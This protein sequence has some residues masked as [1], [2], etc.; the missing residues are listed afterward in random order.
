M[1]VLTGGETSGASRRA[2]ETVTTETPVFAAMSFR[3]VMGFGG[4]TLPP[5]QCSFL[6]KV[7]QKELPAKCIRRT[8]WRLRRTVTRSPAS[9]SLTSW[10]SALRMVEGLG[11]MM[12][13]SIFVVRGRI[14]E[15]FES[16]WGQIGVRPSTSAVGNTT[17]PPA[18]REYAVDPVGELTIRPSQR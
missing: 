8:A 17:A 6:R 7:S 5:R 12:V 14:K 11:L 16:V 18:A 3:R 4:Y 13:T 1:R 2:L 15:R 10:P 9:S